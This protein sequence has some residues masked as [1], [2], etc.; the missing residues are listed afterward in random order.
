MI[1]II[2]YPLSNGT[3]KV[4]R[5]QDIEAFTLNNRLFV[6]VY[7]IITDGETYR[8]SSFNSHLD[9]NT[10]SISTPMPNNV[11][12]ITDLGLADCIIEWAIRFSIFFKNVS[13]W[14]GVHSL[15]LAIS[16]LVG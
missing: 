4:L 13:K 14:R 5:E 6:T 11:G 3:R 7:L 12:V 9:P 2:C 15:P 16:S 1:N 8:D 10:W